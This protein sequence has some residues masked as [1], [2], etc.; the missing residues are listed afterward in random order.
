M[1]H[2]TALVVMALLGVSGAVVVNANNACDGDEPTIM[3]SPNVLVLSSDVAC[4]TVHSNIPYG[5]LELDSLAL[6]GVTPYL[7]K[8]DS[9]GHLV[10]KFRVD[11][12]GS[13]V[14]P[15]RV[16]LTLTGTV[17]NGETLLEAADTITVRE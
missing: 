17:K 1:R 10:A 11:D 15:G 13:V 16:T 5:L 6:N 8:R 7:T 9:L 12:I 4:V 2:A 3:V 14:E